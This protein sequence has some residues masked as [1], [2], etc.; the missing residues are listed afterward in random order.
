[1]KLLGSFLTILLTSIL[2]QAQ[3]SLSPSPV[4]G[5]IVLTA[6]NT[7]VYISNQSSVS[8]N[9]AISVSSNSNNISLSLNRCTTALKPAQ[10]C[11][12][13]VSFPSYSSNSQTISLNLLNNSTPLTALKINPTV[14]APQVSNF[15]V[16]SLSLNDFNAVSF[17]VQ[18]KTSS[19][20]SYSP[21]IGGVDASKYSITLNRC[22]S[23]PANGT[24]Q[25]FVKLA[26]QM[27]GSYS[28]SISEPQVTGSISLSSTITS[29][30][31]GVIQPPNPSIQ[32]VESSISFGTLTQLGASSGKI[33]TVS[34]NGNVSVSP[35]ISVSGTGLSI[36][37]NRCLVLLSPGQS[38]TA[39]LVFTATS[40]MS[41]GVQSGLSF[42]A[43]ATSS[44]SVLSI[45]VSASLN[46]NPVLLSSNQN[47]SGNVI[48]PTLMSMGYDTTLRLSPTGD[49]YYTG[50]YDGGFGLDF[51][52]F[53]D[54]STQDYV[55]NLSSTA[56]SVLTSE[57]IKSISVSNLD[58]F[59][60]IS[61]SGQA[62]CFNSGLSQDQLFFDNSTALIGKTFKQI[63]L[64]SNASNGCAIAN[65]DKIY[66]W[67]VN[68]P[69]S[70]DAILFDTGALSGKT[71][72]QVVA[73]GES[74]CALSSDNNVYCWGYNSSGELG[75]GS[76]DSVLTYHNPAQI[77]MSGDLSGKTIKKLFSHNGTSS[78]CV[79]AS[80]DKSYCWGMNNAGKFG[81]SSAASYSFILSPTLVDTL[82]LGITVKDMSL[83]AAHSCVIGSDDRLYCSG[84]NA[85]GQIGH[86]NIGDSENAF[87][88]VNMTFLDSNGDMPLSITSSD[89][90]TCVNTTND[91]LYCWGY[92]EFRQIGTSGLRKFIPVPII[93]G[94]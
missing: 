33:V 86:G 49:L 51:F 41:N 34:N 38:C 58:D 61:M 48:P 53:I 46:I 22:S 35:I 1:M 29:S 94:Y 44:T 21:V 91:N 16:S 23:I 32:I 6:A 56:T 76:Q 39:S 57:K 64:A 9:L 28:A 77:D 79:I 12:V 17:I 47:N 25:V 59:C 2:A 75:N 20:K 10:S 93:K 82:P 89:S 85:D 70:S 42:S 19:T 65:D 40:S 52:T 63:S 8:Q 92:N 69:I 11:Y 31:V 88:A 84:I 83:G 68:L 81:I 26:P 74:F 5:E 7:Y 66:C 55:T 13:I 72:K 37:L 87:S 43:Q 36:G 18:N 30:T 67:S 71:F 14:V 3:L 45:P 50:G 80:D 90:H 78:Y 62:F 4:S 15:S 60:V 54:F 24:C 27:A 73:N